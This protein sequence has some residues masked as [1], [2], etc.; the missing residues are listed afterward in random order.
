MRKNYKIP[1]KHIG[2]VQILLYSNSADK[3]LY[4]KITQSIRVISL[5]RK[6]GKIPFTSVRNSPLFTTVKYIEINKLKL[7]ICLILDELKNPLFPLITTKA[8]IIL[9][10][11]G[12]VNL[13][14]F[15]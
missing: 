12:R 1:T 7:F 15:L 3:N 13:I 11:R 9:K 14:T 5:I 10:I 2:V 8:N 4:I 6:I